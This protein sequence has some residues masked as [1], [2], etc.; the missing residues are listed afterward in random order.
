MTDTSAITP[1]DGRITWLD[2]LIVVVLGGVLGVVISLA[3]MAAAAGIAVALG[4]H[5]G[6]PA[7]LVQSL[8]LNFTANQVALVT[9]DAG[10]LAVTWW[11]ARRRS[12]AA[13]ATYFPPIGW[14]TLALAVLSGVALSLAING[15]N[16]LLSHAK[17]VNFQESEIER[18]IQP[19]NWRQY[20]FAFCTMA[21]FAPFFEEFFF[22]GLLLRWLSRIGGPVVAVLVTAVLFAAVHGQ[23]ALHPGAQGL[24]FSFELFVAGIVLALWVRATGSLRASFATHAA[25]NA[26]ALLFSVLF[27]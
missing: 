24:L 16:E 4:V 20:A 12:G 23:F 10:F 2:I 26:A 1:R 17:L 13:L 3:A 5:L 18:A 8:K 25:Y 22:R 27:P 15:G 7:A 6:N 9:S 11:I 21:L 14:R 19:H